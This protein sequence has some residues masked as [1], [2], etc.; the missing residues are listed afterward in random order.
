MEKEFFNVLCTVVSAAHREK[1]N[2]DAQIICEGESD[3]N[4]S[5]LRMEV[6]VS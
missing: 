4:R 3:G 6:S 2:V 5:T 1:E